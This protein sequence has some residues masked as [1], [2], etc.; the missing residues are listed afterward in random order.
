MSDQQIL[1]ILQD[2]LAARRELCAQ[3]FA[4]QTESF[5]EEF[6]PKMIFAVSKRLQMGTI[7]FVGLKHE[8]DTQ[9]GEIPLGVQVI[10]HDH[11][12]A[13]EVREF[14][15]P[16]SRASLADA[17]AWIRELSGRFSLEPAAA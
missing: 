11:G 14:L 8:G 3:G 6:G 17:L 13:P 16:A 7:S 5:R 12:F 2:L 15:R 9:Q 10:A 1:S 4:D